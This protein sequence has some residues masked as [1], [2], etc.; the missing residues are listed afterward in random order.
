MIR[1]IRLACALIVLTGAAMFVYQMLP[2]PSR[3]R[4]SSCTAASDGPP[5]KLEVVGEKFHKFGSMPVDT[6]G[7]HTWQ[8]KNVGE[9]PL[10]VWLDE[11]DVLVHG[12]PAQDKEGEAQED[13]HDR[14]GPVLTDRGDLGGHEVGPPVRPVGHAGHQRPGQS[15][16][17]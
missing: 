5:P 17:P 6:K 7:S 15:T 11:Y 2:E 10:E 9:G 4:R 1:W 14:A 16:V 12:R 8:F 13:G 3:S